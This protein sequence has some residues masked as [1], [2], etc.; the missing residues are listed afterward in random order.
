MFHMRCPDDPDKV[1]TTWSGLILIGDLC[2]MSL[3]PK[4]VLCHKFCCLV[5]P[6]KAVFS[7]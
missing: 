4:D 6:H 5:N 3:T 2:Y 7:L 1:F